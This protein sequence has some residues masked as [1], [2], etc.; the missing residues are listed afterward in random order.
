MRL[1]LVTHELPP[2][3]AGGVGMYVGQLARAL[4]AQG[5][6]VVVL[7]REEAPARPEPSIRWED[8]DGV[9]VA[10]LNNT[11]RGSRSFADTYRSDAIGRAAAGVLDEARPDLVH[12]HHLTG[13]STG[14]VTEARRR[15]VPVVITLHDYWLQCHRGQL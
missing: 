4:A 6:D 8:R 2:A 10:W 14:V 1:L 13:L 15:R 9:S 11:W 3:A 7:A 5:D 12:V